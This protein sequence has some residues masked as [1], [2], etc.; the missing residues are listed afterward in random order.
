[1]K[2][3]LYIKKELILFMFCD[4]LTLKVIAGDG[5]KGVVS[6][7]REKF[8]P[9]GGPDGGDGGNGGSIIFRV[10]TNL[11]T[12]SH[13]SFNK[14]FRAESGGNGGGQKMHGKNG[15]DLLLEV[16]QGTVIFTKDKGQTLADLS[17]TGEE[18]IL[19]KGG[20][21]GWGNSHFASSTHQTP[22]FAELGEPGER[23]DI[24]LELKLVADVGIIGLP[25]AGKSTLISV[26]SNARPKIAAYHF[27]TLVPNLG[28]VSMAKFGGSA[29]DSFVVADIP[30]LIE[31]A[32]EGKGLGHKFLRHVSRTKLLV[33]II[34]GYLDNID[35]DYKTIRKELKKFDESLFEKEEVIVV[36]KMDIVEE[37]ILKEK[38]KKLKKITKT[39]K[40]FVISAVTHEGLQTLMFEISKKL[41]EV[42]KKERA[43]RPPVIKRIPILQPHLDKI[44]FIIDKIEKQKDRKIF[45]I[46]GK[47][48][49]RVVIMTD[50]K[51]M[52]GLE[53]IYHYIFKMGLQKALGKLGA[54][55]GDVIEI[56]GKH[57]P[58]RF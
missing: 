16:P 54:T 22:R 44:R 47:T 9:K 39:K 26:I 55:L 37:K 20:R 50:I 52:E 35:K 38:I 24:L 7:R 46:S 8:V 43:T 23:F 21:G 53:R 48:L 57:I 28:V 14:V 1:M 25:S 32:H 41:I 31:G 19:A 49:E 30:G 42:K 40:I 4:E 15:K 2:S 5:G 51:N 12:L 13:L 34:D 10:N 56:K 11:N 58:Y 3:C 18:I 45:H 27:T 17:N 6:F 33:H 29:N 36:N